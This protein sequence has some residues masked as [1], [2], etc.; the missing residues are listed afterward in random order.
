[1]KDF[2]ISYDHEDQ[3]WAEW[4]AWTLEEGGY[5]VVIQA[6]DFRPGSDFVLQMHNAARDTL[7]TIAV[8]TNAYLSAAFTQPEW[9]VAFSTD[10]Q[11]TERKLVPVRVE[12]C[13]PS[14]LLQT[15]VYVDLVGLAEADARASLLGAFEPRVKPPVRPPF[16]PGGIQPPQFTSVRPYPGSDQTASIIEQIR[17]TDREAIRQH[18][19][20]HDAVQRF[21]LIARLNALAPQ[22]FNMLVFA[23]KP[24]PGLVPP[25]PAPLGDRS[26]PL[27]EWVESNGPGLITATNILELIVGPRSPQPEA[28][29]VAGEIRPFSVVHS[30]RSVALHRPLLHALERAMTDGKLLDS[31]LAPYVLSEL[32]REHELALA[33]QYQSRWIVDGIALSDEYFVRVRTGAGERDWQRDFA[34]ITV[35]I[36]VGVGRSFQRSPDAQAVVIRLCDLVASKLRLRIVW[37][38]D[39]DALNDVRN[40]IYRACLAARS[41]E[42]DDTLIALKSDRLRVIGPE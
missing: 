22:Q 11:G 31:Y 19:H 7:R 5:S 6:W 24:P 18:S 2:F 14:G 20:E 42:D 9:A 34:Q 25:M 8:L 40:S 23:L 29:A 32:R 10:P 4:I 33:A 3:A 38:D 39:L 15:R 37:P 12:P 41:L 35:P 27:L 17:P 16:P 1:M 13:K 21:N 36:L 26:A 30:E 28:P